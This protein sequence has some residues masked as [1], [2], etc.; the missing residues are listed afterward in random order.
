MRISR[1]AFCAT[2]AALLA[3]PSG[4]LAN[5]GKVGLW[6]ITITM[7]HGQMGMPDM[8]KMP[9]AMRARMAAAGMSGN[10][11]TVEHCMTAAEVAASM[12]HFDRP[13]G[14]SQCQPTNMKVAGNTMSADMVCAGTFSATGH[15]KFT[16][17]S[18]THYTGEVSMKGMAHGHAIDQDEKFEGQWVSASCGTVTH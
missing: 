14:K 16:F 18:D 15:S 6:K 17:D 9:P 2:I 8:S 13:H 10:T 11:M 12:P 7:P 5:H 1:L 4:A 3:V